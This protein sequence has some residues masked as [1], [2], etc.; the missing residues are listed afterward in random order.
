MTWRL[1]CN[2]IS[3]LKVSRCDNVELSDL[4][5]CDRCHS[6]NKAVK[7]LFI[8]KSPAYLLITIKRFA[9]KK[10]SD[11]VEY[12]E[13]LNLEKYTKYNAGK[14]QYYLHS[15]IIHK[16]TL[17]K[18]HYYCICRRAKKVLSSLT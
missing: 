2:G 6:K 11:V 9:K 1:H 5:E 16:G 15:I 17:E 8:S 3:A 7:Q 4:Y 14:C 10:I 13:K 12:P 18:G